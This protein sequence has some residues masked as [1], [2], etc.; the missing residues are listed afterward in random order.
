MAKSE[1]GIMKVNVVDGDLSAFTEKQIDMIKI[2]TPA[3]YIKKRK[4]KGGRE[5]DYI[6][7]NYVITMLNSLFGFRWDFE[8]LWEVPFA[9]AMQQG[10]VTVKGRLS[11][12]DRN[13]NKLSKTQY[14]SQPMVFEKNKPREPEYLA[15]E[16][17]DL[18]KS[19]SSDCLK[20]C[21][22]LF[23]IALDVYSG[24][25]SGTGDFQT[26]PAKSYNS[27]PSSTS[28]EGKT[29]SYEGA[30]NHYRL[31]VKQQKMVF[32][33]G[34]YIGVK[35]TEVKELANALYG[36]NSI[37]I[38]PTRESFDEF[39]ETLK[40]FPK[41]EDGGREAFMTYLKSAQASAAEN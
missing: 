9:E 37:S 15:M 1:T 5:F 14:G 20:K 39:L 16:V 30:D 19:A 23:G 27:K 11:V 38:Y 2:P 25:F 17:G 18:Y 32:A 8:V 36:L 4:G 41:K 33:I 7:T 29:S 6:E 24:E 28:F 26:G 21:A 10:S 13:G 35:D 12:Y 3:E 22:S 31:S 40:S 34:Y